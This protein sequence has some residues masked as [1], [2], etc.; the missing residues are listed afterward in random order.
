M[1][2][3][4]AVNFTPEIK[5]SLLESVLSLKDQ[6]CR[7]NFTSPENIHLTLAFI[8]ETSRTEEIKKLLNGVRV[9]P[10]EITLNGSGHFG[11]LYYADIEKSEELSALT[12]VIRGILTNAGIAIDKKPFLPHITLAR[13]VICDKPP[14]LKIKKCSMT[15][16]SFS[17]MKSERVYGKLVYTKIFEKKLF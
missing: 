10:F 3:F 14:V 1:R 5:S 11:S 8:G 9:T 4:V 15:V 6:G 13:E 7:A 2:L 17:L 12:S 16:N